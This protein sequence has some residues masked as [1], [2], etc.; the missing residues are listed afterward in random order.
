MPRKLFIAV[1]SAAIAA[2]GVIS[3]PVLAQSGGKTVKDI[4]VAK[5][6]GETIVRTEL[7]RAFQSL[8]NEV[9][10]TGLEAI[11]PK[12]VERLI[13]RR[14]LIIQG[15]KHNLAKDAEVIRRMKLLENAVIGEVYLNRLIEK[16]LKPELLQ[17]RYQA[18]LASNP[19][20]E[21]VHARHILL[22]K[23]VDAT[24]LIAHVQGG[25][26]FA[27]AAKKYSTGP[28]A[29]KGGDLG[30]FGR[31]DMVKPFAD[32]AFVLKKGE[33]TQKPV[34]TKFGWHVIKVEDHR[35]VAPPTFEALK[36][37]LV[38]EAGQG[39]AVA[40]MNRLVETAKVERFALDG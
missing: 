33:F 3:Q 34:K 2:I 17:E 21:E 20:R 29:S 4:V 8:P 12:L 9:K 26:D 13:Q 30:Y 40:V 23:E 28:S 7:L 10:Q 6:E 37:R 38:Q 14:L 5:V 32:A 11:Y 1:Y 39:V 25:M 31:T 15:R 27:E 22:E 16:N 18:F 24:N 19:P 36:P 35:T